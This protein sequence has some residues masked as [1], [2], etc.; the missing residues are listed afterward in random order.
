M[1]A[2]LIGLGLVVAVIAADMQA[3]RA[4]A[5]PVYPWCAQYGGG[6]GGGSNCYFANL[7]QCQ[8]AISGNGGFCVENP[9]YWAQ[10]ASPAGAP[11]VAR[12]GKRR[13]AD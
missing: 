11:P 10:G 7:W 2:I 9:F 6:R 4:S 8:Q 13:A 3:S 1:R 5:Y 12:K